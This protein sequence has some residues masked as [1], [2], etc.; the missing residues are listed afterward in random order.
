[1]FAAVVDPPAKR[2]KSSGLSN[3]YPNNFAIAS[4]VSVD[5]GF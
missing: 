4:C 3:D 2:E 5:I 1:M